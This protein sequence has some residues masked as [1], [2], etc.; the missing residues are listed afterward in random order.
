MGLF[1]ALLSATLSASKDLISK[2]LASR[3]DG[4]SST[5][6]S[7]AF[8]LPYYALVLVALYL[9]RW[10]VLTFSVLFWGLVVLRAIT[11]ALAE[12]LKMHAFAHGDIS[13]VATFFSLAPLF[14]L[15]TSPLITGDKLSLEEAAAVVLVVAGSLLLVYRPS[16]RGWG[17]QRKGIVLAT[18]AAVFFSLNSCF[19]RLAVK[20]GTPVFAGFTMTALSAGFLLPWV[21]FNPS[22]QEKMHAERGGLWLRGFL[23]VAFMISKLSALRYLKA[24]EVVGMMRLSLVLSIVGGKLFFNEPDF[25]RRLAAG[26]LILVGVFAIA[27]LRLAGFVD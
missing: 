4:T 27:W 14:L 26:V 15:F 1:A 21:L 24:T 19:D 16:A 17:E 22:R 5:Y 2:Q 23:E 6:A 3:L 12:G 11:D 10:E 7:F 9:L 20:E 13:I 25:G 8:A 18:L